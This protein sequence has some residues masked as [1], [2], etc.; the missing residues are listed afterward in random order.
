MSLHLSDLQNYLS[1]SAASQLCFSSADD[2]CLCCPHSTPSPCP[3]RFRGTAC[4]LLFHGPISLGE[5]WPLAQEAGL[6][7]C[8]LS[9]CHSPSGG[10]QSQQGGLGRSRIQLAR[11]FASYGNGTL[12][13]EYSSPLVFHLL[14]KIR[15]HFGARQ[16]LLITMQQLGKVLCS[17]MSCISLAVCL[18]ARHGGV[19]W[20]KV[21]KKSPADDLWT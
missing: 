9:F 10:S 17:P 4:T 16:L 6:V 21:S 12:W 18:W 8:P 5:A 14:H 15:Y 3:M 11:A 13:P 20:Y 1:L 2:P 19:W 7:E